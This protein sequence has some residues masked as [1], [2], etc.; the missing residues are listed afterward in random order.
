MK[1]PFLIL[2]LV[3]ALGVDTIPVRAQDDDPIK[4]M[5]AFIPK[6]NHSQMFFGENYFFDVGIENVDLDLRIGEITD[7]VLKFKFSGNLVVYVSFIVGKEGAYQM[8]GESL[9]YFIRLEEWEDSNEIPLPDIGDFNSLAFSYFSNRGY[10]SRAMLDEW[11]TFSIDVRVHLWEYREVE[12]EIRLGRLF[13]CSAAPSQWA[14]NLV[15][16]DPP[17]LTTRQ[18]GEL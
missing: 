10:D 9:D 14:L 8:E 2:L 16:S 15:R 11:V 7:P 6:T 17:P 18:E 3:F 12:D 5:I 1:T 13:G 4:V